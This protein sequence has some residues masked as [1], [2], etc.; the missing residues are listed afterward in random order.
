MPGFID[1][2]WSPDGAQIAAGSRQGG[3][4]ELY[5][6][7]PNGSGAMPITSN[8]GYRGRPA[9]S[10]DGTKIAFDCQV[11]PGNDDICVINA[12]GTGFARLT[13]D[14]AADGAA[15]WKP[16]GSQIAF[17][18]NRYGAVEIALMSSDG[19]GVARI[20]G[21]TRGFDPAWSRDGAKI[22]FSQE[23]GGCDPD[24]GCYD[25]YDLYVMN[26]DGSA[27]V[28]LSSGGDEHEPDWRP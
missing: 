12:D 4:L 17:A 14:P 5:V 18:T 27:L 25:E 21:G 8:V 28:Q 3:T 1:A 22:A 23:N 26:A 15:A 2:A 19:G 20:N 10:R 9:W 13:S 6:M 24:N 11:D 16:D 7:N